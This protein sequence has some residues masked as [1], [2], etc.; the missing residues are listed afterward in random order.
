MNTN[1]EQRFTWMGLLTCILLILSGVRATAFVRDPQG[2]DPVRILDTRDRDKSSSEY[3]VVTPP[4]PNYE[5]A[6]WFMVNV[7]IVDPTADGWLEL[8]TANRTVAT[9]AT[10]TSLLSFRKG[11]TRSGQVPIALFTRLVL[12]GAVKAHFVV[13]MVGWVHEWSGITVDLAERYVDSRNGLGLSGAQ[14]GTFDVP[15]AGQSKIPPAATMVWFAVTVVQADRPGYI[16]V[17]EPGRVIPATT[18]TLN[19]PDAAPVTSTTW[20][21]PD[22]AGRIRLMLSADVRAHIII[23]VF[24]WSTKT[25]LEKPVRVVDSR[26]NLGLSGRLNGAANINIA[27]PANAPAGA[28]AAWVNITTIN[29]TENGQL[30][31]TRAA[32]AAMA[33]STI[34]FNKGSINANAALAALTPDGSITLALTAGVSADVIVDV[35]AFSRPAPPPPHELTS[36]EEINSHGTITADGKT[37]AFST[38][39]KL[40]PSDTDGRSDIYLWQPEGTP[41]LRRIGPGFYPKISADGSTIAAVGIDPTDTA[42]PY[43]LEV[44]NTTTNT[45]TEVRRCADHPLPSINHDGTIVTFVCHAARGLLQIPYEYHRLDGL[46]SVVAPPPSLTDAESI[47]T[48]VS[49]DGNWIANAYV[50]NRGTTQYVGVMTL[51]KATGSKRILYEKTNGSLQDVW[52]GRGGR[53]VGWATSEQLDFGEQPRFFKSVIHDSRTGVTS[54]LPGKRPDG[55]FRDPDMDPDDI[56]TLQTAANGIS[57]NGRYLQ[58]DIGW[59]GEGFNISGSTFYTDAYVLDLQTGKHFPVV[60]DQRGFIFNETKSGGGV[61]NDGRVPVIEG[62]RYLREGSL[63]RKPAAILLTNPIP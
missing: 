8:E 45:S 9:S 21:S 61:S 4:Q 28:T 5:G 16:S 20:A 1:R 38:N 44:Y 30:S 24:G 57:A 10:R 11:K 53:F 3:V 12:S 7:T 39:D 34:N 29:P 42:R 15:L 18:S 23:D 13:D 54:L 17:V 27:T 56:P 26:R 58:Y 33:T 46:L 14:N 60:A 55:A 31:V 62:S 41:T 2:M 51:N 59:Y 52:V 40:L 48:A 32:T 37:V 25:A 6:K 35:I 50:G 43:S 19:F 22:S 49:A 47:S 36:N 63:D